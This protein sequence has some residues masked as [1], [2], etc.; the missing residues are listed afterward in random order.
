MEKIN[1]KLLKIRID[2]VGLVLVKVKYK[3]EV[4]FIEFEE[5]FDE[6]RKIYLKF[7]FEIMLEI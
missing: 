2:K 1:M 7:L 3:D 4:D 5:V 6:Y